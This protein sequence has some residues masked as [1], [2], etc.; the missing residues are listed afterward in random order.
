VVSLKDSDPDDAFSSVPYEKG[1]CFLFYLEQLLGGPGENYTTILFVIENCLFSNPSRVI[2]T[3]R[4]F[5]SA[6]FWL[7]YVQILVFI[8]TEDIMIA[9]LHSRR[10]FR[11]KGEGEVEELR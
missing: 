8:Y 7:C 6:L 9:S 5:G 11:S 3:S 2:G 4:L 10:S 1:S